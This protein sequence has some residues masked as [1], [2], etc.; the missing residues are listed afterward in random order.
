MHFSKHALCRGQQRAISLVAIEYIVRNG[1]PSKAPGGATRYYIPH[2]DR[3]SLMAYYREQMRTLERIG[4][5]E[6]I[7]SDDN[8]VITVQHC[9]Q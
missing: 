4:H 7:V 9:T 3:D 8:T 5:K 2:K 6:V 1:K